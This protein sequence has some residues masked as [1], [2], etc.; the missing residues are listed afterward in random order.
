MLFTF[1]IFQYI[2]MYLFTRFIC[3]FISD[4]DILLGSMTLDLR[5][6]FQG[7]PENWKHLELHIITWLHL[8]C[9]V[10]AF[11]GVKTLVWQQKLGQLS[12]FQS[13]PQVN[14][15]SKILLSHVK[16]QA[17]SVLSHWAVLTRLSPYGQQAVESTLMMAKAKVSWWLW[18]LL[19]QQ[20]QGWRS[21]GEGKSWK[22]P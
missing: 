6:P 3:V 16:I 17:W 19:H 4:Y 12:W 2:V 15:W 22:R 13:E 8:F 14:L 21:G 20:Q 11:T 10:F 1:L 7:Q 5:K 18:H 9:F